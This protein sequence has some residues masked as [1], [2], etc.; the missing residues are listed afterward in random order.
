MKKFIIKREMPGISG[1]P[2]SDLNKAGKGS[3]AVLE[4]MRDEGKDMARA[5]KRYF[6]GF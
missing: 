2:K 5:K 4:E 6:E 3:E 1:A